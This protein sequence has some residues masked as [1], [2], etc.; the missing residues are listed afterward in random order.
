MIR[1]FYRRVVFINEMT[2][3]ELNGETTLSNTT[4]TDDDELVFP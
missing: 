4:S 1:T 3:D 2:L